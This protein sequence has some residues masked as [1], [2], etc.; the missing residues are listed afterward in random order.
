M[1]PE[2]PPIKEQLGG[3]TNVFLLAPS[4]DTGASKACMRLAS[5]P[6]PSESNLMAVSFTRQLDDWLEDWDEFVDK[7]RPN[8]MVY[9]S[10]G[11][12]MRNT[13]NDQG[14]VEVDGGRITVE[15]VQGAGNLTRIGVTI[16]KYLS[17]WNEA[18][19]SV[20]FCFESI[21]PMLHY[22]E[23]QQV[24]RFLHQLTGQLRAMDAIAHYHM[25]PAAHDDV[26]I[27]RFK[28][29]FDAVVQR[30]DTDEWAIS[31]RG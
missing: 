18:G 4:L 9:L 7:P 20:G 28:T 15:T 22:M 24:Y 3:A 2:L 16:S 19:R 31:A 17:D 6:K 29:L 23:V 26:E 10:V 30:T 1:G 27:P 25:D 5:A 21:T 12:S 14:R 11:N 13:V 8:R